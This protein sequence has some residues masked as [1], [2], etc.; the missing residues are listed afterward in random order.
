M[1]QDEN[2][3]KIR[4]ALA[5][6]VLPAAGLHTVPLSSLQMVLHWGTGNEVAERWE[7]GSCRAGPPQPWEAN[8]PALQQ[9]TLGWADS[10][11]GGTSSVKSKEEAEGTS[12]ALLTS[13]Y[14]AQA[15]ACPLSVF[16]R[17][18]CVIKQHPANIFSLPLARKTVRAAI[19]PP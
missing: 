5:A 14:A 12:T 6:Y 18:H 11:M 10:S 2:T 7:P 1:G 17:N 16:M 3:I 8:E 4:P 19:A 15:A 9:P 13:L